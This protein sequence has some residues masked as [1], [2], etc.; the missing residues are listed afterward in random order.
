MGFSV[1]CI[2]I[3]F[4]EQVYNI[5]MFFLTWETI[6]QILCYSQ[7]YCYSLQFAN[8]TG[9]YE[10]QVW[11]LGAESRKLIARWCPTLCDPMDCNSPGSS[12]QARILGQEAIPF[13][14]RSSQS[15]KTSN[16]GLLHCRQI[17]YCLDHLP[18]SKETIKDSN[19][20]LTGSW[21]GEF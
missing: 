9:S 17:L 16:P 8:Y 19:K 3:N 10:Q 7:I 1:Y 2:F 15:R 6:S 21:S 12:V 13:S 20:I 4:L 11:Q 14:R 18:S 5:N